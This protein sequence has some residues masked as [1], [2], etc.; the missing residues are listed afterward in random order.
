V[1]SPRTPSWL[2]PK[3]E[4][5]IILP[6]GSVVRGTV[7]T[8]LAIPTVVVDHR[9][10]L[11]KLLRGLS[12]HHPELFVGSDKLPAAKFTDAEWAELQRLAGEAGR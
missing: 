4:A 2:V 5:D 7:E 12:V 1:S 8:Y 11:T 10:L 6:D 3:H 9:T